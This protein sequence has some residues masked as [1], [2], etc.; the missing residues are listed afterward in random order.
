M[1]EKVF[2]G[3]GWSSDDYNQY[4]YS[5]P[6]NEYAATRLLKA[7]DTVKN[8]KETAK[9]LD[10]HEMRVWWNG[11]FT[12]TSDSDA[13][14]DGQVVCDVAIVHVNAEYCYFYFKSKYTSDV[15]ESSDI[16]RS[17]VAWTIIS[18]KLKGGK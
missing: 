12:I 4:S 18:Y 8:L 1:K 3:D 6:V 11:D 2:T 7:M 5:I 10:L 15:Y 13:T 9:D 14:D 17:E 16:N